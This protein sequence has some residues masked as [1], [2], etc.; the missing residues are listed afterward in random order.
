MPSKVSPLF[1]WLNQ[2]R[3]DELRGVLSDIYVADAAGAPMR[4][5]ERA[6]CLP[7]RGLAEDRYAEGHG[8]WRSVDGCEVTLVTLEDMRTASTANRSFLA[9]EHRRNL[10]ITGIPL[11]AM[12]RQQLRI[13]GV[14]FAFQRLRPPCAHLD[15][16][17]Q[18]GAAKAL[19]KRGGLGLKVIEFGTIAVGD[20]V[21]V[22][23]SSER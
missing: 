14:L 1:S 17:V 16:A 4:R 18:P 15:R 22:I 10:V 23:R 6:D 21:E 8:H 2:W 11:Q 20:E 7:G 3:A 19:R 9:G 5:V 12:I 13:G